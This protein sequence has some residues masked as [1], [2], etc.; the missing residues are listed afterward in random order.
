ML[1]I[2]DLC[3]SDLTLFLTECCFLISSSTHIYS[4]D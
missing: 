2:G 1:G 3:H 4:K